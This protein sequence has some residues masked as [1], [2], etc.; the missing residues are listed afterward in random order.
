MSKLRRTVLSL[1]TLDRRDVPSATAVFNPATQAVTITGDAADNVAAVSIESG[2][3]VVVADG[4]TTSFQASNVRSLVFLGGAGNDQ[5][6]NN[7]SLR[8]HAFGEDGNDTLIGGSNR[9][10]LF[11]GLGDDVLTG[12][13][14]DD[15]IYG[16]AG[17]DQI[18]GND[19]KDDLRGEA[20]DDMILG[21]AG[22]DE[23]RGGSGVD[24]IDGGAGKDRIRYNAGIDILL[25]PDA[26]DRLDRDR[27][28]LFGNDDPIGHT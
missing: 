16:S 6:T 17:N 28:A 24:T 13:A 23:I 10:D 20:G 21:G 26:S 7:T 14:G 19:G 2:N 12:N 18:S 15:K 27:D 9:D 1:H 22:D 5:F 4:V 11:G 8:S 3:V 25:N